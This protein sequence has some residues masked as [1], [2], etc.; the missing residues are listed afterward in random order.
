MEKRAEKFLPKGI[1]RNNEVL[2][3]EQLRGDLELQNFS[4]NCKML[5]Q[6]EV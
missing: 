4:S 6:L 1:I 2:D 5:D 3:V